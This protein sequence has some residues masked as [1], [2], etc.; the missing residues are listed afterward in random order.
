LVDGEVAVAE[1]EAAAELRAAVELQCGGA[2][3]GEEED[4]GARESEGAAAG[5]LGAAL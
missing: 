4:V 2:C 3:G 1:I 5:I